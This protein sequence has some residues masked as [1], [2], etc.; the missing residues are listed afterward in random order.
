[1]ADDAEQSDEP[2]GDDAPDSEGTLKADTLMGDI[3]DRLLEIIR[4]LERPWDALAE[5]QQ[6]DVAREV[7]RTVKR[8]IYETIDIVHAE[9]SPSMRMVVGAV[10]FG[11]GVSATLTAAKTEQERHRLADLAD[12]AEVLVVM[13]NVGKYFGERAAAKTEPDQR[14]LEAH[15]S[16]AHEIPEYDVLKADIDGRAYARLS[17]LK[18]GDAVTVDGDFDCMDKGD[19]REVEADADGA[20]FIACR[21]GKHI[22][23]RQAQADGDTLI[24]IYPGAEE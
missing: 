2:A 23:D 15:L 19:V 14:D 9:G 10:K 17:E 18:A 5:S 11:K 1:M 21:D 20:L 3:R 4:G 22:L 12:G 8:L 24:G 16:S 13:E 7:E 6:I